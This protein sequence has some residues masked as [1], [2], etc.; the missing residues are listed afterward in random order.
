[1]KAAVEEGLVEHHSDQLR[2]QNNL[3]SG[4]TREENPPKFSKME[5]AW[6]ISVLT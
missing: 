5:S 2:E 3:H 1:M 4:K 6:N